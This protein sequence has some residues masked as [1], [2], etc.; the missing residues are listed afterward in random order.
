MVLA[1]V[2]DIAVLVSGV[3]LA[4][5]LTAGAAYAATPGM[6][7][8]AGGT[9]TGAGGAAM[10]GVAVDLYA[11]PSDAALNALKVGRLVPETLLA[12]ATT[13]KAWHVHAPGPGREAEGGG[14]RVRLREPRDLQPRRG[15]LVLL[16][17]DRLA[18]RPP[19]TAAHRTKPACARPNGNTD[20]LTFTG[21]AKQ[22]QRHPA[23]AT[24]GQGYIVPA[25]GTA[26]DSIQF[27]Y[28]QTGSDM[29]ASTLGVGI[30][31]YGFDAKYTTTG[32]TTSTAT[33]GIEFGSDTKNTW[34]QSEFNVGQFRGLC[35]WPPPG[36]HTGGKHLK[37]HGQCPRKYADPATGTN[38]VVYKCL[39]LVR[40]TGWFGPVGNLVHPKHAP[41]TPR[42]FCGPEMA[43]ATP[44]TNKE[45]AVTWSSG[46]EIGASAGVKGVNLNVSFA[47]T[48]QTG[49]DSDDQMNF[50]FTHAGFLC[51]T[52]H[53]PG[54]AA[55]LVMR[56][57]LP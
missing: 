57:N 12:T 6:A 38:R 44:H 45:N 43:G 32:T 54:K 3:S 35:I 4:V 22:R 40:S 51:G 24:V 19:V 23:W 49:Y 37:Q 34:F 17:P 53:D 26:G 8:V 39:W 30:S 56:G 27:D 14:R 2:R 20:G 41:R 18:A 52:N 1:R 10:A 29:Q 31:G 11:W 7:A 50:T 33:S 55:Q 47:S 36:L 25:K 21:F 9:V 15:L 46:F 16:L 5:S 13:G 28:N 48:A 42:K